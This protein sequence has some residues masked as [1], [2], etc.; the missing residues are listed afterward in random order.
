MTGK[1]QALLPV[2]PELLPCPFCGG[3][4]ELRQDVNYQTG[5]PLNAAWFAIC[6][7]CDLIRDQAWSV[8]RDTAIEQWN[9]RAALTPSAL[10]D[11]QR[12]GQE[13]DGASALSGDAGEGE[14]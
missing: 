1:T 8:P 11:L 2:T 7:P 9:T 13:Y 5:E 6:S 12:L 10:S 14:A 4:A 3:P